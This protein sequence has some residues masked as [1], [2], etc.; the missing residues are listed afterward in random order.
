MGERRPGSSAALAYRAL[1]GLGFAA[2]L[3]LS[4]PGHLT[5]DS[6]TQLVEGRAD[7][8]QSWGPAIYAWVLGL[9]DRIAGGT[10][11]YLL[12]S[13]AL[14][15]LVVW[16]LPGLRPRTSWAAVAA[17]ALVAASPAV[18]LY[19]GIVWKDVLFANFA[20]AGF[21]AL[22]HANEARGGAGRWIALAL[23]ALA[24]A[25]AC[26]VRQNG[27][28]V[29]AVA[30]LTVGLRMRER[31]WGRAALSAAGSSLAVFLLAQAIDAAIQPPNADPGRRTDTGL[32][33]LL[34]YDILGAV[35]RDPSIP[36]PHIDAAN[37]AADD[38]IRTKARLAYSPERVDQLEQ[39]PDVRRSF[40]RT[41]APAIRAQWLEV[42][43]Q[44]PG[45]YLAHRL[46]VFRWVFLT[47]ELER[48]LPVA[49]GV[50][51]VP[52][53][54]QSLSLAAGQDANDRRVA[55]YALNFAGTPL[56]SHAAFAVLAAVLAVLLLA[57]GAP[58]DLAIAGMLGAG[59]AT[60][61]SYFAISIACD[62]RYL[63]IL[64]LTAL[65]GLLYFAL[66]PSL[67]RIRRSS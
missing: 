63:Y 26:L 21:V 2:M 66:D 33:I 25:L 4:F 17:A 32:R 39:H 19:Q 54:L 46:D 60:A 40:W 35:A 36:L 16:S 50:E 67:K 28:I 29:V 1:L 14:L 52:A 42:A 57:R 30:A 62:Y 27:L 53:H 24:L 45:A 38:L 56:Y 13:A 61:A 9:S 44:H 3:A 59:L 5:Y 20:V 48:C 10:A 22:A 7:A 65:T 51:G 58:A 31:G 43:T 15:L 47:P 11:A 55:A 12:A 41:P 64:D 34:H 8:Q 18:V 6:V 37:P 23:A 49:V